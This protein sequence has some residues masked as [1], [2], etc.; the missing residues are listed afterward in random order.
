MT[1]VVLIATPFLSLQRPAL[2]I[3]LLQAALVERGIACDLR[4]LNLEYADFE[5][6][7]FGQLFI[8][9]DHLPLGEWIFSHLVHGPD[10][11]A[12]LDRGWDW[13]KSCVIL[14]FAE[15]MMAAKERAA[16]FVE[17]SAQAILGAEP[18]HVGFS[19]SFQQNCASLSIAHQIKSERPEIVIS[20]GGANCQG[21]MGRA[22]LSSFQQIDFVFSGEADEIFPDFIERAADGDIGS[23]RYLSGE[24]ITNM[25]ALPIPTF[26]DYFAELDRTSF[27]DRIVPSLPFESSRGCWW[28]AKHHCV[29]CG[30][31]GEDMGFRS[32][33]P[34]RVIKEIR[35][36]RAAWNVPRFSATDNIMDMRHIDSIFAEWRDELSDTSFFYEIKS[37]LS[38]EQLRTIAAAGVMSVQPGIESLDDDILKL[39]SKGVRALQNVLLLRTCREIGMRVYWNMLAGFPRE[40]PEQYAKMARMIPLLQHLERPGGLR[41]I[42]IDRFSPYHNN[43]QQLGYLEIAPLSAYRE[44]YDLP[45]ETLE[46]LVH[47]FEGTR[48]D[49]PNQGNYHESVRRELQAWCDRAE[50]GD[51]AR[52]SLVRL[53]PLKVVHDTRDCAVE[54]DYVLPPHAEQVLHAFDRPSSIDGRMAELNRSWQHERR[55]ESCFTELADLGYMVVDEDRAVH[56]VVDPELRVQGV[57]A[58]RTFP[59]GALLEIDT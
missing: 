15:Q 55:P 26:D 8:H 32:K 50:G 57:E 34:K 1:K 24:P 38:V 35:H 51:P 19:T 59:I 12:S 49:A 20:F 17:R 36:L 3:S 9:G 6:P 37:N 45:A 27:K 52:L 33:S 41:P 46:D 42:R 43:P 7:D 10:D 40:S 28:G 18:D 53:G 21:P 11:G 47:F 48:D 22:L 44:I 16:E 25:D 2:G 31:N 13:V 14:S 5:G 54:A 30:L 58:P 23:E 56:V 29:F 4:Y 39:M